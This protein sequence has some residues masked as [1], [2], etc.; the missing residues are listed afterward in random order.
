MTQTKRNT[1]VLQVEG[2]A[3]GCDPTLKKTYV[4]K[5]SAMPRRM[6]ASYEEGQGPEVAVTP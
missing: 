1:L 6:E 4:Q 2:W 3:W 5:T